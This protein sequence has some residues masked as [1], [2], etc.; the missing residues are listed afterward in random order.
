M[1]RLLW[2][3]PLLWGC[4]DPARPT[5]AV[6]DAG[7][8]QLELSDAPSLT[9]ARDGTV[10]LR[11][12]AA[13]F[14][15]GLVSSVSDD[16]NYDPYRLE[17]PS[18][19]YDPPSDLAFVRA[20]ISGFGLPAR[21]ALLVAGGSAHRPAK[22]WPAGHYAELAQRLAAEGVTPV[23]LGGEAERRELEAITA[24]CPEAVSLLG[25][26]SLEQIVVLARGAELAVGNDTGPMHL[27]AAAG[28]PSLALFSAASDPA[29]TAPRGPRVAT[30]R[31][32]RLADLTV[33]EVRQAVERL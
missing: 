33:E 2:L 30:L 1:R 17:V 3:V 13:G 25:R 32:E 8:A 26:T 10:L 4:S 12:D 29:R 27:I 31:R 16:H 11:F 9:L 20:D 19:L 15:L 28:C 22:R 18:P 7:G 24:A 21:Y 5:I 23:L 6:L 14:S